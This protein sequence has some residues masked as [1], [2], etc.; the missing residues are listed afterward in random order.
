MRSCAV[1]GEGSCSGCLQV[2]ESGAGYTLGGGLLN[3]FSRSATAYGLSEERLQRASCLLDPGNPKLS[4]TQLL[5]PVDMW[6]AAV[7][8]LWLRSCNIACPRHAACSIVAQ[9]SVAALLGW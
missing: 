7:T 9:A 2:Q 5:R 4:M 8:C 3:P 6:G 1:C